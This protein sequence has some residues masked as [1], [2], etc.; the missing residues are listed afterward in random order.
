MGLAARSRVRRPVTLAYEHVDHR[1]A[2]RLDGRESARMTD[3]D[4]LTGDHLTRA[5]DGWGYKGAGRRRI[6]R[7]LADLAAVVIEHA[8]PEHLPDTQLSDREHQ[9]VGL[10][11]REIRRRA[12]ALASAASAA[13]G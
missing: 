1:S 12:N 11:S 4:H 6:A 13:A 7:R 3:P 2:M 9:H 10:V 5:L 8:N